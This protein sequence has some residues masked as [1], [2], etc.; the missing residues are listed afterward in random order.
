MSPNIDEIIK[1][2]LLL[3]EAAESLATAQGMDPAEFTALRIKY[4]ADRGVA[5]ESAKAAL[6]ALIGKVQA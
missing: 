5:T 3:L 2:G 4:E 1:V 6:R